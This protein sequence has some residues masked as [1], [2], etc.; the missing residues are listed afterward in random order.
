[1]STAVMN[2]DRPA[3]T[4]GLWLMVASTTAVLVV[5]AA[6]FVVPSA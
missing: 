5:G 6:L 2:P 1:M 4:I 3:P